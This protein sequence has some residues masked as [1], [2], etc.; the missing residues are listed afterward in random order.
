MVVPHDR[1]AFPSWCTVHAPHNDM[2]QPNLVPVSPKTSRTY[3]SSGR[4]GSPSKERSTP[5]T[6]SLIMLS[7]SFLPPYSS[8]EVALSHHGNNNLTNQAGVNLWM[9]FGFLRKATA[10]GVSG[11]EHQA[12]TARTPR[13]IQSSRLARRTQFCFRASFGGSFQD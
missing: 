2:P 11:E 5:F 13:R 8:R 9:S 10:S 6:F 3:H 4:S 7:L 12:T 1:I